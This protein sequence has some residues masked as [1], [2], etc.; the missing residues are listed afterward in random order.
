MTVEVF[1]SRLESVRPTSRGWISRCPAHADKTPSLSISEGERGLL[2]RCWA[3][4]TINEIAAVLGLTVQDLFYDSGT[5]R[6]SRRPA[7]KPRRLDWRKTAAAFMGHA[8]SLW[9][10]AT[11]VL[12]AARGL[13]CSALTDEE[14]ETAMDAVARAYADLER[15][16]LLR[17][18]ACSVRLRGLI[19]ESARRAHAAWG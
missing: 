3:G 12:D 2:L 17:D 7:P 5:D 6:R 16:E 1:L 9:L 18:V 10:R 15:A 14:I 4:C 19:A 13:D 11:N 8:D